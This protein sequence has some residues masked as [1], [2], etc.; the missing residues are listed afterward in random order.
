VRTSSVVAAMGKVV[1]TGV[2]F[3]AVAHP[4]APAIVPAR[5]SALAQKVMQC[6][7]MVT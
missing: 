7:R 3:E 1:V 6:R 4:A 2:A 5:T